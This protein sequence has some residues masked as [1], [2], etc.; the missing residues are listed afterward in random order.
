MAA[1]TPRP[2]KKVIAVSVATHSIIRINLAR[3]MAVREV[4][5]RQQI[6]MV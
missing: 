5:K 2:I 1:P 4:G 3:A 6:L